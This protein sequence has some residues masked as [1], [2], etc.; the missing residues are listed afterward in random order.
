MT[1]PNI[2][3]LT[4]INTYQALFFF[5]F[6]FFFFYQAPFYELHVLGIV[7]A[8]GV[9]TVNKARPRPHL[10]ECP[11]QWRRKPSFQCIHK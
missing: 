10:V 1:I 6:F 7:L 3:I 8:S 5:F 2:F 11:D 9:T 4:G